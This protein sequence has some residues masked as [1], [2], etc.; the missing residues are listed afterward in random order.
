MVALQAVNESLDETQVI[1][2]TSSRSTLLAATELLRKPTLLLLHWLCMAQIYLQHV[3]TRRHILFGSS[4]RSFN[5]LERRDVQTARVRAIIIEDVASF[6]DE[7]IRSLW[8]IVAMLES[9]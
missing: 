9:T 7:S 4:E 1:Y 2:V 3:Q 6:D 8:C 5:L